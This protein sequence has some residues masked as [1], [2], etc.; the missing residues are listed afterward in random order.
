[1][2]EQWI[3]KNRNRGFNQP[4]T[5]LENDGSTIKNVSGYLVSVKAWEKGSSTCI[6]SGS[7]VIASGSLGYVYYTLASGLILSRGKY[8][9]ELELIS[10]GNVEL[11]DTHTYSIRMED[12]APSG[13][14]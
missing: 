5:I 9:F 4:F 14:D 13:D 3:V 8:L 11:R 1:M 12:S 10:S 2:V 7:C 6:I